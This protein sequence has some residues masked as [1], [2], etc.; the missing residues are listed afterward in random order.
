MNIFL[1]QYIS[2]GYCSRVVWENVEKIQKFPL[3]GLEDISLWIDKN[4]FL[5][6]IKNRAVAL[7][8]VTIVWK[9]V[10]VSGASLDS[11]FKLSR[12]RA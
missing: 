7:Q 4:S 3:C 1:P 2:L 5:G 6:L 8:E 10:F 11:F 12:L 9:D